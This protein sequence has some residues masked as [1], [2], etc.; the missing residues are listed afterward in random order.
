MKTQARRIST[1]ITLVLLVAVM[2]FG[3]VSIPAFAAEETKEQSGFFAKEAKDPSSYAYSIAV[4]GDTQTLSDSDYNNRNTD[5]YVK[6]MDTLYNWI[7]NN[8]EAKKIG[9]VLGLGDIVENWENPLDFPTY[10][11][12]EEGNQSIWEWENAGRVFND[13]LEDANGVKLPYTL[14]R[15]NHDSDNAYN[16]FIASSVMSDYRAQFAGD[17]AGYYVDAYGKTKYDTSYMKLT[18]GTTH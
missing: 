2:V 18:I 14:V 10:E 9:L 6:R 15:G 4:I 8:I 5:G 16:A 12:K 17:N 1:L 3:V 11:G 13:Y 7:S